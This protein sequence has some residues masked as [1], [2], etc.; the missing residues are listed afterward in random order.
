MSI[1]NMQSPFNLYGNG[2]GK[3]QLSPTFQPLCYDVICARGKTAHSHEG[4][5]RFRE[6]VKLHQEAYANAP[7]KY[8][9]SLIVSHITNTVRT[10]SVEGGFV[11]N[12]KGIWYE[13]GD[14]AAKEKIGQTLRD[15][16]HTKYSSSTKAKARVRVQKRVEE[17]QQM[18]A[19]SA[20]PKPT[21][22][23]KL[24][25]KETDEVKS[26]VSVVS[27][28]SFS[29]HTPAMPTLIQVPT[30]NGNSSAQPI[31]ESLL[32]AL[33]LEECASD[34]DFNPIPLGMLVPNI[35]LK[36]S[37]LEEAGELL[38]FWNGMSVA[39]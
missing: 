23:P 13:V 1:N 27:N 15:L 29:E 21:F 33:L 3:R 20:Q 34:P 24:S 5:R 11:K 2:H 6:L 9:K 18:D 22:P 25:S 35:E 37:D 30:F 17:Y 38:E 8:H 28:D 36:E 32:D 10:A 4:N 7:T 14:R 26:S 16:L 19:S 39:C 31:G 12:I